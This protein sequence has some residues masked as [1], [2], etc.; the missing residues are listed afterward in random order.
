MKYNNILLL[1][2]QFIITS[3]YY[4]NGNYLTLYLFYLIEN[5]ITAVNHLMIY[6]KKQDLTKSQIIFNYNIIYTN[7]YFHRIVYYFLLFIVYKIFSF[8]VFDYVVLLFINPIVINYFFKNSILLNKIIKYIECIIVELLKKI[9]IHYIIDIIKDLSF[10][11]FDKEYHIDKKQIEYFINSS[12]YLDVFY[13]IFQNTLFIYFILYTKTNYNIIYKLLFNNIQNNNIDPK[14]NLELILINKDYKNLIS[15]NTIYNIILLLNTSSQNN[16]K[17]I[18]I[19]NSYYES[20]KISTI[21]SLS[22][23]FNALYLQ[24]ILQLCYLYFDTYKIKNVLTV[25]NN[26]LNKSM[27]NINYK[28]NTFNIHKHFFKPMYNKNKYKSYIQIS[29]IITLYGIAYVYNNYYLFIS[30]NILL[31][32]IMFFIKNIDFFILLKNINININNG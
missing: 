6:Y 13:T 26:N 16:M 21:L 24:P 14:Y 12:N 18:L 20:L 27:I 9:V 28:N 25:N 32:I 4:L 17:K 10:I 1:F 29:L 2:W 15:H 7:S 22:L 3:I 31:P 11:I 30:Y 23:F 5:L 19:N 8:C